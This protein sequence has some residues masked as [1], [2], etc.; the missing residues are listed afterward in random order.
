MHTVLQHHRRGHMEAMFPPVTLLL[1]LATAPWPGE[2]TALNRFRLVTSHTQF[3]GLP[4]LIYIAW[5][6]CSTLQQVLSQ[7]H[8]D[9]ASNGPFDSDIV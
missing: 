5:G 3:V 9:V 4:Y 7:V 8:V 1:L 2:T 6:S